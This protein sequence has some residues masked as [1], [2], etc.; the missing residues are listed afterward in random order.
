M[1][2]AGSCRTVEDNYERTIALSCNNVKQ[3][4]EVVSAHR[5][6]AVTIHDGSK[7]NVAMD[8]KAAAGRHT[9]YG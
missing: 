4:A 7:V 5:S 6:N 8:R 9:A 2:L 3:A 1:K